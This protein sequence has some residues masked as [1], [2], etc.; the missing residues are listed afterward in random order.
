VTIARAHKTVNSPSNAPASSEPQSGARPGFSRPT[1]S[2]WESSQAA[3]VTPIV[4]SFH[5][6]LDARV[7]LHYLGDERNKFVQ[8]F[9]VG[10]HLV[11]QP[12]ER[13]R[14]TA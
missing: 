11:F 9:L 4:H 13:A 12:E 1:E 3:R 14:R 8:G 5:A 7:E 2:R 6:L 10:K